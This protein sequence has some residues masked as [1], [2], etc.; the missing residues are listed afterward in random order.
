[1]SSHTVHVPESNVNV[2]AAGALHPKRAHCRRAYLSSRRTV[3]DP[4]KY[5][6]L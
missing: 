2:A 3:M 6:P 4:Q 5:L 1:M